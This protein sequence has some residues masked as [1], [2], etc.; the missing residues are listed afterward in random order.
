MAWKY[1]KGQSGIRIVRGWFNKIWI[2]YGRETENAR[3]YVFLS[4]FNI[5][6]V[7]GNSQN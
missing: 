1:G 2:A 5:L 7:Y 4:A 6:L 3:L